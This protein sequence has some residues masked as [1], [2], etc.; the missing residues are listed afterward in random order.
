MIRKLQVLVAGKGNEE[1]LQISND[2]ISILYVNSPKVVAE[3]GDPQVKQIEI[4]ADGYLDD[5]FGE[6]FF[7]EATKLSHKLM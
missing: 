2:E 6:G 5:T 1:D 4:C 3:T 7:D